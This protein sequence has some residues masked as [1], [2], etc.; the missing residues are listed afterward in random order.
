MIEREAK[1]R[2]QAIPLEIVTPT[3]S[4]VVIS[5]KLYDSIIIQPTLCSHLSRLLLSEP[6]KDPNIR[7]HKIPLPNVEMRYVQVRRPET[8]KEQA[9]RERKDKVSFEER[10]A[11]KAEDIT[12][13]L[14][15]LDMR[16]GYEGTKKEK[17]EK[18][19]RW[20]LEKDII[21]PKEVEE[22]RE[23]VQRWGILDESI[24]TMAPEIAIKLE[25][26]GTQLGYRGHPNIFE[27]KAKKKNTRRQKNEVP[28]KAPSAAQESEPIPDELLHTIRFTKS[29]SKT[30]QDG[31][32]I[33]ITPDANKGTE[34]MV[35]T[36]AGYEIS[37]ITDK[38]VF[39]RSHFWVDKTVG[40][41]MLENHPKEISVVDA[42]N[43]SLNSADI[44]SIKDAR[45]DRPR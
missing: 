40:D 21:T 38:R 25:N 44:L 34:A 8:A 7:P 30:G 14:E 32:M 45:S 22:L 20:F 27:D 12:E 35:K 6:G 2:E 24:S 43:K 13:I 28:A 23:A 37:D 16:L 15:I 17:F 4:I 5:R 9:E 39:G 42:P 26:F 18:D 36:W 10:L 31:Y 11:H 29:P 1:S 3:H 19:V 33:A 41:E